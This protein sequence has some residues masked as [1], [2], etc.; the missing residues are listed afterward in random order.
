VPDITIRT[1]TDNYLLEFHFMNK[2][3]TSSEMTRYALEHVIAKYQR[4]LPYL[5]SL[6]KGVRT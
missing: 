2:Q 1:D 4:S 6:L 5:A 3:I